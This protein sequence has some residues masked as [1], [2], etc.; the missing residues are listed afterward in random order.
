MES[1][2]ANCEAARRYFTS[3]QTVK[4]EDPRD[5]H[6]V[7]LYFS[8]RRPTEREVYDRQPPLSNPGIGVSLSSRF[9]V[10]IFDGHGSLCVGTGQPLFV[11][12]D[13]KPKVS[14]KFPLPDRFHFS[15]PP[16]IIRL[17]VNRVLPPTTATLATTQGF[18]R[19]VGVVDFRTQARS[20]PV[21]FVADAEE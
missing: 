6:V 3:E 21:E 10:E 19:E 11:A 14:F 7:R 9:L 20:R 17:T 2:Q 16:F 4:T 18:M 1:R 13:A 12:L 8:P 15:R 5:T